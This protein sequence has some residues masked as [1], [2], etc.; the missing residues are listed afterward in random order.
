L[1]NNGRPLGKRN[2]LG[3]DNRG[4][5]GST[6]IKNS[7]L[8]NAIYNANRHAYTPYVAFDKDHVAENI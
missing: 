6:G 1:I 3:P 5:R 7:S 4:K 2:Y 8:G